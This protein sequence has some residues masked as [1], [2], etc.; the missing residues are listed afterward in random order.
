MTV[1]SARLCLFLLMIYFNLE[2][3]IGYKAEL[4]TCSGWLL[5]KKPEVKR[6]V[7]EQCKTHETSKQCDIYPDL[8]IKFIAHK[9]PVIT[10]EN[11]PSNPIDLT[12]FSTQEIHQLLRDKGIERELIM[13]TKSRLNA[14]PTFL[15]GQHRRSEL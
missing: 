4:V 3:V 5:N 15:P 13:S 10:F 1:L 11:D 2:S 9:P 12:N 7:K 8:Y 14:A 6:F